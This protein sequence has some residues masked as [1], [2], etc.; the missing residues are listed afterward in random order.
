MTDWKPKK[1]KKCCYVQPPVRKSMKLSQTYERPMEPFQDE[2]VHRASYLP[3]DS[4]TA[5]ECRMNSAKPMFDTFSDSNLKMDTDT[6]HKLSY[7]PVDTMRRVNPTWAI[8]SPYQKPTT[9]M[10]LNTIYANSYRLPGKFVECDAGAPDNLIVTYAV[11]CADI[12]GLIR[13]HGPY[14]S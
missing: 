9:S 11:N 4:E 12:D 7:Q 2:T 1:L 13:V 3:I 5:K 10:D 8:K 6:V 14:D